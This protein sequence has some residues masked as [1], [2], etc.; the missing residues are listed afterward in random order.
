MKRS[1]TR[2]S[3]SPSKRG[4]CFCLFVALFDTKIYLI[5][6]TVRPIFALGFIR[7][8]LTGDIG[9]QKGAPPKQTGTLR[10]MASQHTRAIEFRPMPNLMLDRSAASR[11]IRT[12]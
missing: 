7:A 2:M 6:K 10:R 3:F 9:P 11:Q 8:G 4:N 5:L 12:P 1:L